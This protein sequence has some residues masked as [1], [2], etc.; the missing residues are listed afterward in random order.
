M[1]NTNTILK[2]KR[3]VDALTL[4]LYTPL[5]KGV[6]IVEPF[7]TEAVVEEDGGLLSRKFLEVYD[8]KYG[9]DLN[10]KTQIR[11]DLSKIILE[12]EDKILTKWMRIF[13]DGKW[14]VKNLRVLKVH[15]EGS[16]LWDNPFY[17]AIS[18]YEDI[19]EWIEL[20]DGKFLRK[21]W[22]KYEP[23]LLV[24]SP[25]PYMDWESVEG[26]TF[27]LPLKKVEI[28]RGR[29]FT[30]KKG[31]KVFEILS[32]DAPHLLIKDSWGGAFEKSRGGVLP[33]DGLYYR[34]ASSN[35][36]GQGNDYAVVPKEWKKKVSLD[37]F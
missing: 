30:S 31:S 19:H 37:E 11:L 20:E 17:G 1:N 35:G 6:Y 10:T 33:T 34:Q 18:S 23:N 9:L 14:T 13:V 2:V 21:S 5:K 27:N 4:E 3:I 24:I 32:G 36:G 12:N 25:I 26:V 28:L 22:G 29:F 7:S 15:N 8:N 16:L